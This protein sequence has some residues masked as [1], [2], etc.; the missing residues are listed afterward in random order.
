VRVLFN[1]GLPVPEGWLLDAQGRPTTDAGVLYRDPRGTILPLGGAQAYKG[2]GIGLLLDMFVGGLSGASC[3][4]PGAPNLSAN[5]VLFIVLDVDQFAGASHFLTEV[6]DLAAAVR[7]CPRVEGV[8]E[9][10][11]PGDPERREKARR[12]AAGITLDDG[13]WGQLVAVA[14]RLKVAVPGSV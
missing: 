3:S 9:I 13:T 10:L 4:R 12:S 1:K 7:S 14:A 8:Q 5:A 2:F 6:T 11:L